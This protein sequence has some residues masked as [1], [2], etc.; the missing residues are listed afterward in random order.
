MYI[1][2]LILSLYKK[3]QSIINSITSCSKWEKSCWSVCQAVWST[4][5]FLKSCTQVLL[6][7][8]FKCFYSRDM[9]YLDY[10]KLP[11]GLPL[12]HMLSRI[13]AC[14]SCWKISLC[15]SIGFVAS[16]LILQTMQAVNWRLTDI[17]QESHE[18]NVPLASVSVIPCTLRNVPL[19][20]SAI[21]TSPICSRS[22]TPT[23]GFS[24][25]LTVKTV[26]LFMSE[27]K[28][29]R[30]YRVVKFHIFHSD[31]WWEVQENTLMCLF[32]SAGYKLLINIQLF[33]VIPP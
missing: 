21:Y 33:P 17:A 12:E 20:V 6:T 25:L 29:K 11:L 15:G 26:V 14:A 10:R 23:L 24:I 8:N 7:I 19:C 16:L 9:W 3:Y 18:D 31:H 22:P 30:L 1:Q 27:A 4:S 13:K 2:N 5:K 28:T 32:R